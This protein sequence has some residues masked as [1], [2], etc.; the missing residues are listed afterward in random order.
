MIGVEQIMG[1][2]I[3]VDVRGSEVDDVMGRVFDWFR[4][5]DSVFS[6]YRADSEISRL[7]RGELAA[8]D[9]R[10]DV[11]EVLERCEALRVRTGGYFDARAPIPGAVDP[12]GLVKGWSVDRA[13]QLLEEAGERHYSVNA[14][15]DVRVR[16]EATPGERWRVGIQHPLESD[17]IAAVVVADDLAIATSGAYERGDHVVD[18]H[19]GKPPTGVLSVTVVGPELATADAFA[20]AAFAMGESGPRWT[21]SLAPY[22]AMTILA[23]ET[24]L[25]TRGFPASA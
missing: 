5:V 19:T 20:T 24:V 17:R 10:E 25:T 11:R 12:S 22:E 4:L 8:E 21:T 14:G 1:M 16:G 23:D 7:N 6:T 15:G 13:A 3:V 9:L 2:P 18:P